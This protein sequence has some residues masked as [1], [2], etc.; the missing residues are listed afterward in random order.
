M[1]FLGLQMAFS[2]T[3]IKSQALDSVN[4]LIV[5]GYWTGAGIE[6]NVYIR[7]D[8]TVENGNK[9]QVLTGEA[10]QDGFFIAGATVSSLTT[11]LS[12]GFTTLY[13]FPV[14]SAKNVYKVVC[15][16]E[17][18][19]GVIF[20]AYLRA[21]VP[22][23]PQIAFDAKAYLIENATL[24]G[25]DIVGGGGGASSFEWNYFD[26]TLPTGI[27]SSNL[28]SLYQF[29]ATASSLNDRSGNGYHL[30]LSGPESYCGIPISSGNGTM[31]GMA[32]PED[33]HLY[34]TNTAHNSAFRFLGAFAMEF[35]AVYEGNTGTSDTFVD[36]AP[37]GGGGESEADNILYR[38]QANANDGMFVYIH[39]YGGG[40]N[41]PS[42]GNAKS[43]YCYPGLI[44]HLI[45][46]R[47]SNGDVMVYQNGVKVVEWTGLT[48]PTGGSNS[49]LRF[50]D[51]NYV[52]AHLNGA[53]AC[54]RVLDTSYTDAQALE[55]Y[56]RVR[57][58]V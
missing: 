31:I 19:Q 33:K 42:S 38:L 40:V 9:K 2:Y 14:D 56:R 57:G 26:T 50:G 54:I 12:S 7:N 22:N 53:I 8:L 27:S 44:Q 20:C 15:A 51:V 4:N 45:L 39:E 3:Q 30:S 37:I 17:I 52:G 32:F 21:K 34:L 58:I 1:Q 36:L 10:S 55:S 18:A 24:S 6:C 29:D 28:I 49:V 48:L 43:S 35:L 11:D 46:N 41:Q 25:T 13:E 47:R 23:T 16:A 5:R